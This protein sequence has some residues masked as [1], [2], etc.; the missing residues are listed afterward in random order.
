MVF[1]VSCIVPSGQTV[2][3]EFSDRSSAVAI[4]FTCARGLAQ[5]GPDIGESIFVDF[6]PLVEVAHR[7]LKR[8]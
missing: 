8:V 5:S 6:I 7:Q 2:P 1:R 3:L 4:S